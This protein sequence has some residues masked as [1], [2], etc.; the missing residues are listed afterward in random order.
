MAAMLRWMAIYPIEDTDWFSLSDWPHLHDMVS[1]LETRDSVTA[2]IKA[3]GMAARPFTA[4]AHP[5]L[6]EGVAL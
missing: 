2:L 6:P 1:R 4:P 5:N 3:E